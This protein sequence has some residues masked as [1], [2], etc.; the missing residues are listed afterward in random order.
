M[1]TRQNACCIN[2]YPI[3]CINL[4]QSV[5][6]HPL[7]VSLSTAWITKAATAL[8]FENEQ[9]GQKCWWEPWKQKA[10]FE[11]GVPNGT[12]TAAEFELRQVEAKS[13]GWRWTSRPAAAAIA[14]S[15]NPRLVKPAALLPFTLHPSCFRAFNEFPESVHLDA[16]AIMAMKSLR[17]WHIWWVA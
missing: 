16:S 5:S 17:F 12:Q 11:N 3:I 15:Q 13:K 10:K 2:L 14:Q 6:Y 7:L 1:D 8:H 4:Y 9:H